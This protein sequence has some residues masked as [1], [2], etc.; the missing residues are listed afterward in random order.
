MTYSDKLKKDNTI[1]KRDD[2][3]E[4]IEDYIILNNLKP[5]DKLPSER[6]MCNMWGFSRSTV[7]SSINKLI[8]EGIIYT[9]KGNGTFVSKEKLIR[10]L[11]DIKGLYEI[12]KSENR[13]LTTKVIDSTYMETPKHIGRKMKLPI[14]HKLFKITRIRYLDDEPFMITTAYLDA[15][16]F[17]DIDKNDFSN[18]SLYSLLKEKYFIDIS[19]GSQK[20]SITYCSKENSKL[21]NISSN[22]AVI[23]QSG[24]TLDSD[25]NI[26][27]YFNEFT[28]PGFIQFGSTLRR[29]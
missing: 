10:N 22:D 14:G 13:C 20:L 4:K 16:R 9:K 15:K 5:D 12:A 21:L 26:F 25:N 1:K 3:I 6:D 17:I 23:Y 29:V 19:G 7:R 2:G 11:Q 18:I 27:E 8:L 28:K 24:I